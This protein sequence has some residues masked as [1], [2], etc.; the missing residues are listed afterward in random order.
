M[1]AEDIDGLWVEL[2]QLDAELEALQ[3][4]TDLG[5]R[6]E[7]QER[8][9]ELKARMRAAADVRD[10]AAL[11][12]RAE[13]LERQLEEAARRRLSGATVGGA[14]GAGAALG[15]GFGGDGVG[16]RDAQRINRAL[17]ES[18]GVDGLRDELERVRARLRQLETPDG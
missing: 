16:H 7:I 10:P 1:S 15:Y 17:D 18:S 8:R 3:G 2:R 9:Q 11:R 13:D 12:R 5:R 14:G 6:L 4:G